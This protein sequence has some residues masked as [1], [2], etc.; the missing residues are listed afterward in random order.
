MI[1]LIS[2]LFF[3]LVLHSDEEVPV[4]YCYRI[5]GSYGIMSIVHGII[6]KVE[7]EGDLIAKYRK[8]GGHFRIWEKVEGE[9]CN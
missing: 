7:N 8:F 1:R 9:L 4:S 2:I 6:T 5:H 3:N